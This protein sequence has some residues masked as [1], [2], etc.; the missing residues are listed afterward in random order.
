MS[1]D[2]KEW[3]NVVTDFLRDIGLAAAVRLKRD[4]LQLATERHRLRG[5]TKHIRG[6]IFELKTKYSKM[7]YRCLYVFYENDIVILF[8]FQK[9]TRKTP[10]QHID[11]A[12]DRLKQLKRESEKRIGS[13]TIH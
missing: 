7:E 10:T 4:L 11:I 9:K 6:D 5:I 1:D 12:V 13:V 2:L 8:C 3:P